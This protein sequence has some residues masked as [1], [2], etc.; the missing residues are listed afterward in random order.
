MDTSVFLRNKNRAP[1]GSF[2]VSTQG[3]KQVLLN[4]GGSTD[5]DGQSLIYTWKVDGVA[6]SSTSPIVL[7]TVATAGSHTFGLKVTDPGDLSHTAADQTV[8]VP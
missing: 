5:P 1:T 6:L 4:G 2:T 3:N 7:H 8:N